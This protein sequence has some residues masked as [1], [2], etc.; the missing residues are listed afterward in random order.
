MKP[1]S[2]HK[3]IL[4][5]PNLRED[6][7]RSCE[8][9][10]FYIQLTESSTDI[11]GMETEGTGACSQFEF[12]TQEDYV[13]D[14][15]EAAPDEMYA[16][17]TLV[18]FG[19]AVKSVKMDDGSVKL[20]G[21]LVTFGDE[22]NTDLTGDYF[23]KQTDFGTAVKSD[24]WF[25]HRMPVE[26]NGV[27]IEYKRKLS[28]QATL[29]VDDIGVFAEVILTARNEYEQAIIDAGMAGK[30]GY[31]SGTASHLVEREASGKAWRITSW[32]LGLDASLT[33]TPAE[34]YNKVIPLKSLSV[35]KAAQSADA[36]NTKTQIGEIT[37]NE[38]ELNAL[39]DAREA[40]AAAD[41]AAAVALDA[42]LQAAEE[43]GYTKAL[44]E[45]KSVK[46]GDYTVNV[47][48]VSDLG[49]S[50]DET[51]SFFH[52]LR[53]GDGDAYKAAM[54]G[55]TDSEGGYAVPDGFYD[56]IIG[57]RNE[58][59]AMRR[60]G[61]VSTPTGLDRVLV[62]TEATSATKFVVTAEEGAY[63][64]NEPTL[65]QVAITVHKLTKLIKISEELEGDAKANFGPWLSN[66]WG[67]ALAA[68]ENYYFVGTG[69]GTAMP[70]AALIGATS[71]GVTT[72]TAT[73]LTAANL[74]SLIYAMPA[75][76]ADN[77]ALFMRRAT[78]GGIRALA[79]NPFS[80]IAT[81][82][83][84]GNTASN[85]GTLHG[86][87]VYCTDAMPAMGVGAAKPV[88]LANP[89]FYGIVERSGLTVQRNPW[90][91]QGTGQ[92]G[93]F[94]NARMGGAVLQAEALYYLT[95]GSS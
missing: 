24:V 82:A 5:A 61:V 53:T 8:G 59:S 52:F 73:V 90:L 43:V 84:N 39:L 76:Y 68:A 62:P 4:D 18:N 86:V 64:E 15:W 17:K 92:I 6:D 3:T 57:K 85:D 33:P 95:I 46:R 78:L 87:P 74:L 7:K 48:K 11:N 30:L 63:D 20:G 32:P 36:K 9:C 55:Q 41:K 10:A 94:S 88:L 67:R 91:Y 21:Y 38:L 22:R 25:N 47:K 12:P 34:P 29:T 14:A 16:E 66:V 1:T 19:G 93:L 49:F 26:A 60:A 28:N 23:T 80:F 37:M 81:P 31:S 65:G 45:A 54:Q 83:D 56:Q 89:S 27:A 77:M 13:C 72:S 58:L 70:Q 51:K 35:S 50:E 2:Y 79:G 75:A 40:K 71:S 44:A 69:T 42:K